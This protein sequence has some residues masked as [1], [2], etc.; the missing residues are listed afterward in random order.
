MRP[1]GGAITGAPE[2]SVCVRSSEETFLLYLPAIDEAVLRLGILS[3]LTTAMHARAPV[4]I[5]YGLPNGALRK[6]E[7]VQ[8]GAPADS[9]AVSCGYGDFDRCDTSYESK[10]G[11]ERSRSAVRITRINLI[12]YGKGSRAAQIYTDSKTSPSFLID[13][14]AAP[15]R[16]LHLMNFAFTAQITGVP[17]EIVSAPGLPPAEAQ[18]RSPVPALA[19]DITPA[20]MR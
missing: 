1:L 18:D 20:A 6:I 13:P 10:P 3:A 11:A 12:G 8:F 7:G 16:F 2:L 9:G 4:D 17:V 15:E 5:A 19:L 14:T